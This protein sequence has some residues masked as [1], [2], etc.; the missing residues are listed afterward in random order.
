MK[1]N[2]IVA[3]QDSV[4]Y[5]MRSLRHL[6]GNKVYLQD[7]ENLLEKLGEFTPEEDETLLYLAR[8]ISRF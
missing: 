7:F 3:R 8:D 5:L 2:K 1:K 4:G 6:V